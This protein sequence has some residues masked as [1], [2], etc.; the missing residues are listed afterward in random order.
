MSSSC[1]LET[2]G[3]HIALLLC[4]LTSPTHPGVLR[5]TV[6]TFVNMTALPS[7]S[8][9]PH[10]TTKLYVWVCAC[11]CLRVRARE[12]VHMC[13]CT[14]CACVHV[15]ERQETQG[16]AWRGVAWRGVAWHGVLLP[17]RG[18]A[19]RVRACVYMRVCVC[20]RVCARACRELAWRGA[21]VACRSVRRLVVSVGGH[22]SVGDSN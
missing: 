3:F 12:C 9:Q 21:C 16:V 17:W 5:Q 10:M 2:A 18:V 20:V 22:K 4:L 11:A 8:L 6:W 7:T 14:C 13:A 19:W 15:R 1:R